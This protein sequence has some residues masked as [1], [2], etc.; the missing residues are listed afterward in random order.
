MIISTAGMD[1]ARVLYELYQYAKL[2]VR[3]RQKSHCTLHGLPEP[4]FDEIGFMIG[5]YIGRPSV[6]AAEIEIEDTPSL[7]FGDVELGDGEFNLS[8][9]L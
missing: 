9:S 3:A 7:W 4:V 1:R 5:A 8:V 2:V 6:S